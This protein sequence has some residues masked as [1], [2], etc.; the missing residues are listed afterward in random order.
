M[1]LA[2]LSATM[3]HNPPFGQREQPRT[4]PPRSGPGWE[5]SSWE[6]DS[7]TFFLYAV[8]CDCVQFYPPDKRLSVYGIVGLWLF[9]D[10]MIIKCITHVGVPL[11]LRPGRKIVFICSV[12]ICRQMER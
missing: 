4:Q 12:V 3:I 7:G 9:E 6:E 8:L 10:G 2:K 5:V 11:F 1:L